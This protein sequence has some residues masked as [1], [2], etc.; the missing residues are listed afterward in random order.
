MSKALDPISTTILAIIKVI[1]DDNGSWQWNLRL[2]GASS[3]FFFLVHLRLLK[4]AYGVPWWGLSHALISGIGAMAVCYLDFFASEKITGIQEPLRAAQC[5]PP[6]TSLHRI[7]PAI[8]MGFAVVDCLEARKHGL[9]YIVHG[10]VTFSVMLFFTE[11]GR[12][13]IV[14]PF[15]ILE[16]STIFLNLV[17]ATFFEERGSTIMQLLFAL[18]FTTVRIILFPSLHANMTVKLFQNPNNGCDSDYFKWFVLVFGLI[19]N[20]LNGFWFYKIIRKMKRKLIDGTE[21]I[22]ERIQ[23]RDKSE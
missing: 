11:M 19:Y 21:R 7:L 22:H 16:T 18:S 9:D 20:C 5:Y 23:N 17:H 4:N 1:L 6:L 15:I 10:V 14:A 3:A 2:V 8:V 13:Q 12:P